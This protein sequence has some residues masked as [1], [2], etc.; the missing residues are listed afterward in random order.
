MTVVAVSSR[1]PVI[2]TF[3]DTVEAVASN[4]PGNDWV[5][6]SSKNSL[7]STLISVADRTLMDREKGSAT[8]PSQLFCTSLTRNESPS[9]ATADLWMKSHFSR[10]ADPSRQCKATSP[11][12]AALALFR[13][14]TAM[15]PAAATASVAPIT[16]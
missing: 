10:R 8:V 6:P 12:V 15:R 16:S 14:M 3:S 13:L 7:V 9:F 2:L 4:T 1:K 5:P 11:A